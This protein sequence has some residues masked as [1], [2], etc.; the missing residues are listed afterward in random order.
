MSKK[1]SYLF[2]AAVLIALGGFAGLAEASDTPDSFHDFVQVIQIAERGPTHEVVC[3]CSCGDDTQTFAWEA[4]QGCSHYEGISCT[5][6]GGREEEL[7]DCE[8]KSVE[9][10][11]T[12]P[13]PHPGD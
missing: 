5:T 11:E 4:G 12:A 3:S 13:L 7:S 9:I 10:E 8:A 2:A 6:S 1:P